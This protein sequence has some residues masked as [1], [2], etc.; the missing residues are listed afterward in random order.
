MMVDFANRG[1]PRLC[2]RRFGMA[3]VVRVWVVNSGGG[4]G[5]WSGA[6]HGRRLKHLE[7]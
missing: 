3:N 7:G 2:R 5:R 4:R 1:K 6:R